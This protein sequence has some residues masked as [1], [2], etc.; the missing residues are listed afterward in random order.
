MIMIFGLSLLSRSGRFS[1]GRY[2]AAWLGETA[3]SLPAGRLITND[4]LEVL[5]NV[6]ASAEHQA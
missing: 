3:H 2:S 1:A 4:N 6:V 5:L